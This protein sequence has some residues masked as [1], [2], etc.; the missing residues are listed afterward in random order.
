[1][2]SG[3]S[4]HVTSHVADYIE[5]TPFNS[6][7]KAETAD[8]KE[9]DILG[10]GTIVIHDEMMDGKGSNITLSQVLFMPTGNGQFYSTTFATEKG[11]EAHQ[12][13]E[14]HDVYSLDSTKFI[15][16][17]H[18]ATSGLFF[19]KAEVLRKQDSEATISVL[20]LNTHDL[21]HQHL[22]HANLQVIK[23]LSAHV[24]GGP[25]TGAASPPMGLCDGC[26]KGKSKRLPFPPLKSCAET[27]LAL[28]HSDLDEMSAAS[29][30][31]YKW[32]ATYLDDHTRYGMM[33]F[34][35]HKDEQ[36]DAFKT[37]KAW[38]ECHTGQKLKT[39][40]TNRGGE[41]LSK[42]QK[43][44]LQECGIE[45]QTS[46]PYSPQQN[47]RAE[48]FQQTIINKVESMQHA[49]GLS[50]GFWKHAVGTAVHIYNVTPISK[51]KFLTPKE[52]W[53]G[54]K[55]DILHLCIFGCAAYEHILKGKRRKLDLKSR[56][57]I[58]IG[59]KN[60]LKGWQFWD[61]K[62]QHIKISR[63]VKFNKSRF[64]L[65]KDLDQRNPSAVEKRWSI[66]PSQRSE[67]TNDSRDQPVPGAMS[68][69]DSEYLS[70]PVPPKPKT[71]PSS[72]GSSTSASH[73]GRSPHPKS[74]SKDISTY[75]DENVRPP[76]HKLRRH[77][78]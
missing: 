63:D 43:R 54:S 27:T 1:M 36:F 69:S 39:I 19:F 57:M 71:P 59:Y 33:F 38:E 52:M 18:K 9:L 58:F 72:S 47:G 74:D 11:C 20:K 64:P 31:R 76:F 55:P 24:I 46:M 50:D 53:S 29:I 77:G 61:A 56:E 7:G 15:T 60:L 3:C 23:A 21:W 42:E 34:L 62:N 66:S 44:Y 67:S 6:P 41:F 4:K 48:H 16:R 2:D 5:Y 35:K 13:K 30:N 12:M 28:V 32:T 78:T 70:A 10:V 25:A 45:H 17:T 40:R 14:C 65:R 68:D 37:Y 8:K 73:R 49:A 51:A 75:E 26:E 22:G